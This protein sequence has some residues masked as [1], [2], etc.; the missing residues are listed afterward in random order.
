MAK[1]V[2]VAVVGA[3]YM[4]REHLRAFS[5]LE[6]V[7]LAGIFSRTKAR[8]QALA[9]EFGIGE[10]CESIDALYARAHA[11]IVVVCVSEL[12]MRATATSCFAFPWVV[13]LEKPAG[14]DLA[15]ALLIEKE[16][17]ARERRVYVALNRRNYGSTHQALQRLA[18]DGTPRLIEIHDQQD[19][20]AAAASGAPPEVVRN[21]MFANS[22][23]VI[24]Y[25]RVF[26]RGEVSDVDC[27]VPWNAS[28]PR[29]VVSRIRFASGDTGMYTGIWDG[30]GPWAVAVTDSRQYLEMRPLESLVVQNR[31]ERVR[32]TVEADPLDSQFKPG[33]RR[34][35][36]HAVEAVRCGTESGLA[37]LADATQS[38][39]L[40]A[41]IFGLPE[42]A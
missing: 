15:D 33:L 25:L 12:A 1:H 30:P 29:F 37:T 8:A 34:Q 19:M 11:D 41:A 31:G 14:Y 36:L 16:A 17:R 21:Y 5:G 10:V 22:I 38:M 24:D 32:T 35:A 9:C 13:L 27:I 26:G 39:R 2:K 4:A 40:C 18:A 3:G 20:A 6:G 23:H 42:G 7:T 28:R